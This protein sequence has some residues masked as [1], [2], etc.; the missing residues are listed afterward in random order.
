MSRAGGPIGEGG[1]D[2]SGGEDQ[3]EVGWMVFPDSVQLR[4]GDEESQPQKWQ[5]QEART[6]TEAQ[7]LDPR[8]QGVAASRQWIAGSHGVNVSLA[9]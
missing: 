7:G 5:G 9:S 1:V 6:E 8:R 3:P 2:P 4:A